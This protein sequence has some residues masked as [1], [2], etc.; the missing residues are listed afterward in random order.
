MFTCDKEGQHAWE[1]GTRDASLKC[2]PSVKMMGGNVDNKNSD[3]LVIQDNHIW[4]LDFHFQPESEFIQRRVP[5][6]LP[7]GA[8]GGGL[9]I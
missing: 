2:C 6:H 7:S 1:C 8:R 4:K 5:S 9:V 3:V